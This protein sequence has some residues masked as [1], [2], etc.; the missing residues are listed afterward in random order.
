MS[1]FIFFIFLK[2]SKATTYFYAY[3]EKIKK[4]KEDKVLGIFL[5]GQKLVFGVCDHKP[6]A[7]LET[8]SHSVPPLASILKRWKTKD[9]EISESFPPFLIVTIFQK[10]F[11]LKNLDLLLYF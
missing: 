10:V 8:I 4:I 6:V 11:I 7:C 5:A 2:S 1:L 3:F 9:R